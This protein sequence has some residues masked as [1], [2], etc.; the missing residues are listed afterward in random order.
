[1]TEEPAQYLVNK[2]KP[3]YSLYLVTD[4]FFPPDRFLYK[5]QQAVFGGVTIV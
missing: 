2:R 3:D 4:R 5:V 1:M